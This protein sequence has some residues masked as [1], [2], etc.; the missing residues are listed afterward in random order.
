MITL[1]KKK[2]FIS[3][4]WKYAMIISSVIL[5]LY[6]VLSWGLYQKSKTDF[7]EQL[8]IQQLNN[9]NVLSDL[10]SNSGQ[11]MEQ[12]VD[13]LIQFKLGRGNINSNEELTR[14][15]E[16]YWP[17]L[18]ITWD[19]SN[20]SFYQTGSETLFHLG[21]EKPELNLLNLKV[22]TTE[23]PHHAIV[24]QTQCLIYAAVP[25]LIQG[26][27][28]G[29]ISI[30]KSIA[31]T[32]IFFENLTQADIGLW[33]NNIIPAI[34]NEKNNRPLL[35]NILSQKQIIPRKVGDTDVQIT[36]TIYNNQ[37]YSIS[38][39]PVE[40]DSTASFIIINHLEQAY[41]QLQSERNNIIMTG[42]I[43]L[44][45]T[46]IL[47]FYLLEK[48]LKR[49]DHL[50]LA[51]PFLSSEIPGKYKHVKE[52]LKQVMSSKFGFDELDQLRASF[53]K[54]SEQLEHLENDSISKNIALK[55]ERD[56]VH[57]LIETAPVYIITQDLSGR[58]ISANNQCSRLL[59]MKNDEIIERNFDDLFTKKDSSHKQLL[60]SFRQHK[61]SKMVNID[62][63]LITNASGNNF[64]SW[65]H[66]FI[67]NNDSGPQDNILSLG[68]DITE[69]KRAE[70]Q[71]LW[72]ASHDPLTNLHNRRY[73]QN[74]FEKILTLSERYDNKVA[75]FYL[76]LDQFKIVNDTQGHDSG[77]KLLIQVANTLSQLSRKS[78]LLCRLGGDE[79]AIVTTIN[80]MQGVETLA[81]KINHSMKEIIFQEN[82]SYQV[83]FSVGVAIYPEHGQNI[84]EL[85]TNADLAMYKAKETGFNR[86]HIYNPKNNYQQEINNKLEW[87]QLIETAIAENWLTLYYQPILDLQTQTI[88]HYE[89]LLRIIKDDG[90]VMGPAEFIQ[91]SEQLGLIESIDILVI[92]LAIE[93]HLALHKNGKEHLKLA[94]NLSGRSINNEKV[95]DEIKTLL[96]KPEVC[97]DKI[98]FE[99]TETSAVTNF[100]SAQNFISEIR[101]LGCQVALDDFGTGFSS[102]YYLKNMSFDYIK[103]D[104]AFIKRID[105]DKEDKIFVKALSDVAR[106]LGKKTIA[107]FVES[108]QIMTILKELHIDYAQGYHISKPLPAID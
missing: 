63:E 85:L 24:C 72:V 30:G 78:D 104:G 55:N 37:H 29:V 2:V 5:L 76:D 102:F 82:V 54:L 27:L 36:Q 90:E 107:E 75:L 105:S 73:F 68:V 43:S 94:I 79:F 83:G 108:E 41:Q 98:I 11:V 49:I 44:L 34:T 9:I 21:T 38:F 33:D 31:D 17:N 100:S 3:L 26:K 58:I 23:R 8:H 45:V 62:D 88:S 15:I 95:K 50:L 65:I 69:R 93:Q 101:E 6:F 84:H 25:V 20:I 70:D 48:S 60:K 13:S 16:K 1:P 81:E 12:L 92:N 66:S 47:L 14:L 10:I 42:L 51:L 89:C 106:A 61:N 71:T 57:Q 39:S 35:K 53:G 59:G 77:D 19:L 4:K 97:S 64:I 86:Y 46:L 28:E 52:I 74:E 22:L 67:I 32:F 91:Y 56:F 80:D 18:Q 96:R 40:L 99:I 103:I 87:K 7:E